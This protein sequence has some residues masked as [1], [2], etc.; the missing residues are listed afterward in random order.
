MKIVNWSFITSTEW[1]IEHPECVKPLLSK[2]YTPFTNL[3][4]EIISSRKG[5]TYLK[6]P[7]H[8]DFLKN[9]FVFR[10]PF[11]LTINLEIDSNTNSVK[12]YCENINQEV[13]DLIIDKRF[14]FKNKHEIAE[15]P[16]LGIDWLAV[17]TAENSTLMQV[18]PAFMHRNEFTEK[19]TMIPGEYDI[20]KWTRPVETVFEIRSNKERIVIKKDDAIAYVKFHS[21]DVVKLVKTPTPYEEMKDCNEIRNANTFR[22]L[23]ERYASLEKI[24]A[25]KCPY[26]HN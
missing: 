21:D 24:R 1:G 5:V 12:I 20:S 15:V 14:L 18:L 25:S 3:S 2:D 26:N 10:A 4:K 22:P 8:T 9:T 17:F 11:D 7:A 13:F 23:K 19:T 6:C 16:L